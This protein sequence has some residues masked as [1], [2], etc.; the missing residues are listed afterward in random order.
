MLYIDSPVGAGFS[1][2]EQEE[3]YAKN[4]TEVG[5]DLFNALQQFFTL[6]KDLE[7]NEFYVAG[8][9]FAGEYGATFSKRSDW[10]THPRTRRCVE[11]L[12]VRKASVQRVTQLR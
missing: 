3:G 2:T 5:K 4:F 1:Y 10:V 8:E 12:D 9:S 6:F 7:R 11:D